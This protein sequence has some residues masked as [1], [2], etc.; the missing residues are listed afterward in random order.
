[1]LKN[2]ASKHDMHIIS[3]IKITEMGESR[4][5]TLPEINSG[6]PATMFYTSGTTGK[7][8]GVVHT[9][10]SLSAQVE[11]LQVKWKWSQEDRILHVLPLH[12]VHGVVNA[13]LCAISSGATVEMLPKF[14]ALTVWNRLSCSVIP[15]TLFMGVPTMYTL[16]GNTWKEESERKQKEWTKACCGMR[17]LVCGSDALPLTLFQLWQTISDGKHKILERYGMTEFGM[18]LSNPLRGERRPN[19]VGTPLPGVSVRIVQRDKDGK[20]LQV[21]EKLEESGELE[22]R[23]PG[24]FLE[25]FG[26]PE[27]TRNSFS[28]GWFLTGDVARALSGG[29]IRIL[30]RISVDVIKTGGYKVCIIETCSS[31]AAASTT[32]GCIE[33]QF[34]CCPIL[35]YS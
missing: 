26:N 11:T 30:G 12:H 25:Y 32:N 23:A 31:S 35:L 19:S 22:V 7:P 9:H 16:L 6:R 8:K 1:M 21:V 20:F 14:N 34:G 24:M 3:T 28:D 10:S 17:L 15:V 4:D 27:L 29:Y 2:T 5:I 18:A 33:L 13:L